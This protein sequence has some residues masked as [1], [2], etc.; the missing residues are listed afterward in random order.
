MNNEKSLNIEGPNKTEISSNT[1]TEQY[2]QQHA[3]TQRALKTMAGFV[4]ASVIV[5]ALYFGKE[6]F[7]PLALS[8]LLAFLLEP[9]VSRLKK[10]GLPQLPS[11]ALVVLMAL[12]VLG[13]AVTYLG[14]Q[15]GSLSQELPQYQDTIKQKLN[16]VKSLTSG[17]SVWDGA[18]A[19]VDTIQKSIQT[20]QPA[21]QK[22]GVQQVQ[23]V[24]AQQSSTDAAVQWGSKILSPLATAG[25][26]FLFVVLILLSRKD[27][28]DRLLK[29]LGGNLNVGTDALDEA[30]DRIGTYLRMQLLVNVSYGV[31]MALG[32]FFIGVPAAIMWGIVA[33]AMRFVPYVGPMISAVFPITLAFAVDP[34]WNMVLWTVGLVLLLELIS[35]NVIEPWLYGESTGLST[36]AIIIA[37]TFWTS[38]WGPVG[39]ILSTPLTACLLVL[40]NYIPALSFVKTLI[41]NEPVLSPPER[42]YQRLVA[43]DVDDALELAQEQ[44]KQDLPKKPSDEV[45]VRKVNAF[46]DEVAIPAIRL[47]SE[48]HNTDASAEH[49]LRMQQG[50]KLFNHQFQ[51]QYPIDQ[52]LSQPQVAC[53]GARW[54][55][56]VMASSMLA[57]GLNLRNISAI[58]HTDAIIQ[59]NVNVL[60]HLTQQIQMV[61]IS[62]FHRQP[63][64]QV[65]LLS[66]KVRDMLP[67]AKLIFAIWGND[68]DELRDEILRRFEP[69]AVVNSVNE[70]M[71][72][73]DALMLEQGENPAR[74]LLAENESERLAA[75]HELSLL[76]PE[77]LPI[78]EQFIEEACQAFDVKYAQISLV[79]D[80]WVNTPAS[81]L[82]DAKQNPLD[83]GIARED[84]ICTHLVHQNE[85]L[86]I[87]DID[88]DP[89]FKK[90]VELSKNK[91]KFYAGVPLRTKQGLVLGSLCILDK[92]TRKMT[93]DDLILLN[94]LAEEL[95]RTLSHEKTK[96]QKL[97]EIAKLQN[98]EVVHSISEIQADPEQPHQA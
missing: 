27:L 32:L 90:N 87:E 40:A 88:R 84:S 95:M 5:L 43:D 35:N 86:I 31:P 89:R 45:V 53:V 6:I 58:S 17:P 76:N 55:V 2:E 1:D 82:A 57:H 71:L 10:W 68:S 54:E 81:P 16:S 44:I 75:L 34:G 59:S 15:L 12:S 56:D 20:D 79:D 13:G 92:H 7:I 21:Q 23:V 19:T 62:V 69:D 74:E 91:I 22:E 46:Y 38:V 25:I 11:I 96:H 48:S 36:L 3:S 49:R 41:G 30:A 52:D 8:V 94:E 97:E 51:N 26:V 29:L 24:G 83:A 42:F 9:L 50:L 72:S 78:Y 4:I 14:Y 47:F 64:A 65:R 98:A 85:S 93:E 73:I 63:M 67:N 61:C 33:I 28:H 39:L 70:L 60:E 18:I 37:A 77:T 66:Q 80:T